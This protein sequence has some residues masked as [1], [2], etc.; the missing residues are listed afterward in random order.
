[1]WFGARL[2]AGNYT[3]SGDREPRPRSIVTVSGAQFELYEPRGQARKTV[4]LVTG[5]GVWGEAEPRL[6]RLARTLTAAGMRVAVPLL[7]GLKELRFEQNDLDL[8]RD[9]LRYILHAYQEPLVVVALSTGG[10]IALTL[11]TEPEFVDVIPLIL[12]F[13]PICDPPATWQIVDQMAR[14][15]IADLQNADDEIW[16]HM[17]NAYRHAEILGFT[18]AEKAAIK[19]HLKR[20]T[21]GLTAAEKIAFYQT[22]I[23][24]RPMNGH[25]SLD[26]AAALRAVSPLGRVSGS[27]AR[28]LVIHDAQDFVIPNTHIHALKAELDGRTVPDNRI[29]IT[30]ALAHVTLRPNYLFDILTMIDMIGELFQ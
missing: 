13:S 1:L 21:L 17:V 4:L 19:E 27:R 30:P 15:P 11:S 6:I 3:A 14:T 20:Y 29:L 28:V 8:A 2:L 18:P 16:V 7:P 25:P 9:C 22:V 12:L 5:V 10:S 26:E 23:A 24:R